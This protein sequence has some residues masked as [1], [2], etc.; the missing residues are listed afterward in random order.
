MEKKLNVITPRYQQI[1]A[2]IAG[3]IASGHYQVGEK[4]YARS[5]IAS[6]YG[7]SAETARR[8]ICV[9]SDME[10]VDA[11]KGSGVVIL[12]GEKAARF[13]KQY[14]DLRTVSDLKSEILETVDRQAAEAR[15][16]KTLLED[17]IDRTDRL[18]SINPFIPFEITITERSAQLG[19]S[20]SEINFWHNTAATVIG[21]RRGQTLMMSPGPYATLNEGDV[22][23]FV[24]DENCYERVVRFLYTE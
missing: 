11:A 1:A 6:Q 3:K 21:I 8:A 18:K 15:G 16:L 14:Q 17:L 2:D 20:L 23:Y 12:S 19:R 13:V 5:A 22:L 24:G 10:I 7:V 4:I 9:L